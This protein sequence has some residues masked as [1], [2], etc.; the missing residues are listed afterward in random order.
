MHLALMAKRLTPNVTIYT[1]GAEE[2]SEQLTQ[3]KGVTGLKIHKTPITRLEK[4]QGESE[5]TLH[6]S[7]GS[8]ITEG[9]LVCHILPITFLLFGLKL[10]L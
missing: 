3:G 8:S 1:D 7:D 4:S 2:L 6:F 10:V 5:V 9:F